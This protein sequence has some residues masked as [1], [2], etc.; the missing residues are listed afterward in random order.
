MSEEPTAP[1]APPP[2]EDVPDPPVPVEP[3]FG[4]DEFLA[5]HPL[6]PA[7]LA[8]LKTWMRQ[9]GKDSAGHY[10]LSQWEADY[11]AMIA[12]TST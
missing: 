6:R 1:S 10:A 9:H 5:A 3:T 7:A 4:L 8:M 12:S 2:D 11:Q